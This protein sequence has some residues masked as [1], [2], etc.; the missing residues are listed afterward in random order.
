[1]TPVDAARRPKRQLRHDG[2]GVQLSHPTTD[3]RD[4]RYRA[5]MAARSCMVYTESVDRQNRAARLKD[6]RLKAGYA[7]AF[8]AARA[9]GWNHNTYASNENGNAAYSFRRAGIYA[10]AF[11]KT[12]LWLYTGEG[13]NT[14]QT[15]APATTPPLVPIVGE[16]WSQGEV[17]IETQRCGGRLTP[18]P[19]GGGPHTVALQIRGHSVFGI[20]DE[21][22]L[23]YFEDLRTPPAPDMLGQIVVVETESNEVLVKRLQRGVRSGRF[24]LVGPDVP[25][26]SNCRLRWAAHIIAI[27]PPLQAQKIVRAAP[28]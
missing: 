18:L 27:I 8:E 14:C 12:P 22:G 23:I 5:K 28:K 4:A 10:K 1:M 26:R 11:G 9:F 6:A 17:R 15:V 3:T 25:V 24:D 19:P 20:V 21:G 2:D 16:V 7:T 13:P